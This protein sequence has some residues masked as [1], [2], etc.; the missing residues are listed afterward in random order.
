MTR[1]GQVFASFG[2]ATP[3]VP[4][5]RPGVYPPALQDVGEAIL[6]KPDWPKEA[7]AGCLLRAYAGTCEPST[8][9]RKL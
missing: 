4:R 9:D 1:A 7:P 5:G 3:W 6:T 8:K 2:R